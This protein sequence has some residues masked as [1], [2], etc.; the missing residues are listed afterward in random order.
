MVGAGWGSPSCKGSP[1][2]SPRKICFQNS[3]FWCHEHQKGNVKNSEYLI[4]T[5]CLTGHSRGTSVYTG[6]LGTAAAFVHLRCCCHL[7]QH[8]TAAEFVHLIDMIQTRLTTFYKQFDW[9]WYLVSAPCPDR[10]VAYRH[11]L[12]MLVVGMLVW[13]RS[14][15]IVDIWRHQ[16]TLVVR[17][18]LA[19][20]CT[21]LYHT[22]VLCACNYAGCVWYLAEN[23]REKKQKRT[24]HHSIFHIY[25]SR[26]NFI[27]VFGRPNFG[28]CINR[29]NG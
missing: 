7:T 12:A 10:T 16:S 24:L 2:V 27:V 17:E 5:A 3:A 4:T 21:L 15:S 19:F 25:G 29:K 1:W 23:I 8:M 26:I 14:D 22:C 20:S 28:K 6:H 9:N 13:I 18:E 11:I